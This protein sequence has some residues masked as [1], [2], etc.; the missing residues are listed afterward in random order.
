V[1]A[2]APRRL[3]LIALL[4][5]VAGCGGGGGDGA[6]DSRPE[7]Q[8]TVPADAVALVGDQAVSRAD[9]D[10]WLEI[11][12]EQHDPESKRHTPEPGDE[13]YEAFRDQTMTFLISA[14]WIEQEAA[15]QGVQAT[16]EEV[17][18]SF[19]QQKQ[20]SFPRAGGYREFL[21][22][23]GQTEQDLIFRVRLDLLATKIRDA[24]G[25]RAGGEPGSEQEGLDKFVADFRHEY[26]ERTL[27]AKGF[28]TAEC[29]N[30]PEP[31]EG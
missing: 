27:C 16:D 14:A 29:S 11:A 3:A 21:E 26:R 6:G 13:G 23:S 28:E 19:A 2:P 5:L 24:A 7:R 15:A 31:P 25:E 17:G 10:H 30:G 1:R 12:A 20:D 22:S 4:A 9:F 18:Q 8:R